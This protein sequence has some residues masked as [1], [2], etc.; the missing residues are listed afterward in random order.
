[1]GT[2]PV[3]VTTG[4]CWCTTLLLTDHSRSFQ[5]PSWWFSLDRSF[6][7]FF[8]NFC[9]S[10]G[11]CDASRA[12]L[13]FVYFL[14]LQL[15]FTLRLHLKHRLKMRTGLT[16]PPSHSKQEVPTSSKKPKPHRGL[17][18]NKQQLLRIAI[19]ILQPCLFKRLNGQKCWKQSEHVILQQI[20]GVLLFLESNYQDTIKSTL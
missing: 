16:P 5:H 4:V 12:E 8:F 9:T 10:G 18:R 7:H 11:T 1:M 6:L 2:Q 14:H 17:L 3:S 19:L 13:M 15:F 20:F